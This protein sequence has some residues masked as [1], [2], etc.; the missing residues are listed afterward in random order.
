MALT[1]DELA[2][3]KPMLSSAPLA[4]SEGRAMLVTTRSDGGGNSISTGFG[5]AVMLL[6]SASDSKT[7]PRGSLTPPD[8]SVRT[9]T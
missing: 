6:F 5:D 9:N 2:T 1:A 7:L 3:V 8:T 4:A